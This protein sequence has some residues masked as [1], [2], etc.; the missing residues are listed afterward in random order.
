MNRFLMWVMLVVC[1]FQVMADE[2]ALKDPTLI[3]PHLKEKWHH[4]DRHSESGT[5]Q[6]QQASKPVL[7]GRLVSDNDVLVM[8]AFGDSVFIL[9][10]KESFMAG[11][12]GTV[13]VKKITP[14]QVHLELPA[15]KQEWILK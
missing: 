7:K 10:E 11:R 15:I 5:M 14:T 8:I 13:I 1:P 3:D 4:A 2:P 9:R 12:W 6:Q